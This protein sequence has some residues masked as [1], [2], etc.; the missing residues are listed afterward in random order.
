MI[1]YGPFIHS[2]DRLGTGI[3]SVGYSIPNFASLRRTLSCF[4]RILGNNL[5]ARNAPN[6]TL[7]QQ[8]L[9]GYFIRA[10][11]TLTLQLKIGLVRKVEKCTEHT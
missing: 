5:P 1:P 11:Y 4:E 8:C 3:Q 7:K 2:T 10:E 6:E 9:S